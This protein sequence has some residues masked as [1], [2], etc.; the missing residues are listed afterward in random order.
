M[1]LN[2]GGTVSITEIC[3]IVIALSALAV[4]VAAAFVATRLLPLIRRFEEL[5]QRATQSVQRLDG[6]IEDIH[7]M[8]RDARNIQSRVGNVAKDL[9]NILEPTVHTVSSVVGGLRSGLAAF[10][11]LRASRAQDSVEGPGPK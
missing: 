8:A 4:G 1:S 3:L 5:T 6:V 10:L 7:L 9:L 2:E 11:G